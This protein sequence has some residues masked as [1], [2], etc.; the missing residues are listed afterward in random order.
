MENKD[1]YYGSLG[2]E[3]SELDWRFGG[4]Y[5]LPKPRNTYYDKKKQYH[6]PDVSSVSCTIFGSLGALSDLSGHEYPIEEQQAHW[7][8]ALERGANP[9]LGWW[10]WKAVDVVRD[11]WNETHPNDTVSSFTVQLLGEEFTDAIDAGYSV[12]TGFRG[13]KDYNKDVLDGI[14]DGDKFPNFTYG[15]FLR[16]VKH[17]AEHYG[18]VIDNYAKYNNRP[19][20][21]AVVSHDQLL[22][23]VRN[24]V[25]YLNGYFFVFDKEFKAANSP[26]AISPWAVKP[27]EW[28]KE[29]KIAIDWTEP[30]KVI[31]D[32]ASQKDNTLMYMLHQAG[33]INEPR[34]QLTKEEFITV[35]YRALNK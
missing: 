11:K 5:K 24:Q 10:G 8:L 20:A 4:T 21:Y 7:A 32:A 35:L 26:Q 2:D 30:Q 31:F 28:G 34:E 13:N 22:R 27:V 1:P 23:L 3:T 33:L 14:L 15:H 16:I 29:K 25:F 19:N 12:V 18:L 6:Q 9:K 17:D